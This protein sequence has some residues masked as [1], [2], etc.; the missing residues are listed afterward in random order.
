MVVWYLLETIR[1]SSSDTGLN[2]ADLL[3]NLNEFSS[4]ARYRRGAMVVA[5]WSSLNINTP[6]S[7]MVT[8][9]AVLQVYENCSEITTQLLQR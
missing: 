1:V 4:V 9:Y 5:R 6:A 7:K 3:K 2:A 8:G